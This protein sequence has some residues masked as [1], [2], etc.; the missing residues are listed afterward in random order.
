MDLIGLVKRDIYYRAAKRYITYMRKI[1]LIP[2][3]LIF[4]DMCDK[5]IKDDGYIVK[6]GKH[7]HPGCKVLS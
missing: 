3:E 4:C 7:Y 6:E 2:N 5:E 1:I